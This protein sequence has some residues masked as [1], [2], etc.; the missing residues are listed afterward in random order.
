MPKATA[1]DILVM[2]HEEKKK[3][4]DMYEDIEKNA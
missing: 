3:F 1:K 2:S 4:A